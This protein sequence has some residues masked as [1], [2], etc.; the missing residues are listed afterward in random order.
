MFLPLGT[1]QT[2]RRPTVVT[3]WLIGLCLVLFLIEYAIT[4]TRPDLAQRI[5]EPLAFRPHD[6]HWWQPI[7]YQFRHGSA[8][9]VAMN[10]LFLFVFG[11]DVEAR[12][13]RLGFLAFFLLSGVI[14]AGAQFIAGSGNPMIG[15]SGSIAGVTG[16]F[17]VM[18]PLVSVRMLFFFFLIGVY[19]IPAWWF[20]AACIVKDLVFHIGSARSGIAY[21]AHLGGYAFGFAVAMILL[22]LKVIPREPFD[23]FSMGRQ[24]HRRRQFKELSTGRAGAPWRSDAAARGPVVVADKAL[25]AR[26]DSPPDPRFEIVRHVEQG[27]LAEAASRYE[28]ALVTHPKLVLDRSSQLAVA[29]QLVAEGR[30]A[31]ASTA[32]T[33][34]LQR[35]PEDREA[36]EVRLMH[37]VL[38]ARYLGDP[39]GARGLLDHID[40]SR[41][42]AD[43]AQ[44]AQDLADE[45]RP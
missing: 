3:Y 34:F 5:F 14:A 13:R 44:L 10:M 27:R 12:F 25:S 9:H 45:L 23:L 16:A 37:A 31:A 26:P 39:G 17:L 40:A 33:H 21:A 18:F 20:I 30:H 29:N 15:A 42:D 43:S 32:Y 35:F 8:M 19:S 22:W 1:D 4:R 11:P 41:L 36:A 2:R 28:S 38:L 6:F 7:T 24:A